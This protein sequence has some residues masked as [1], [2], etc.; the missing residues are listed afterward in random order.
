MSKKLL[1]SLPLIALLAAC[2][3]TQTDSAAQFMR[4]QQQKQAFEQA[5]EYEASQKAIASEPKLLLSL[6]EENVMQ[7]RYFAALAYVKSYLQH[8]KS[9]DTISIIHASILRNLNQDEE[10]YS[11]YEQQLKGSKR[12]QAL[13][14]LALLAAKQGNFSL[15][16]NHLTEATHLNPTDAVALSDLGFAYLSLGQTQNAKLPLG[17]ATELDPGNHRITAN[18]AL[19]LLMEGNHSAAD[20]L[21]HSAQFDQNTQLEV[22][23]LASRLGRPNYSA[24]SLMP[25]SSTE[26][27]TFESAPVAPAPMIIQQDTSETTRAND[28]PTLEANEAHPDDLEY[29][30]EPTLTLREFPVEPVANPVLDTAPL[31][32]VDAKPI[33]DADIIAPSPVIRHIPLTQPTL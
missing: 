28:S 26:F 16:V 12:A 7:K 1:I 21:M 10:A 13:H 8:H 25:A 20:H 5:A 15:A 32:P 6:I 17:Q 33:A 2:G 14:G 31:A 23:Q 27:Q 22:K 29:A 19:L 18:V 9:D 4:E 30:P 11:I 24:L 3:T